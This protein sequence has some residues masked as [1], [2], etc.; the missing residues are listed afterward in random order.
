MTRTGRIL[1]VT[2]GLVGAG[3]VFG[4]LAGALALAI[5]LSITDGLATATRS[6]TL[7]LP[8][9][10]GAVLG[11]LALPIAGWL[12]L[13]RVPLGRAVAG[14]VVGTVAGGAVV[15]TLQIGGFDTIYYSLAG[16]FAGFIL[17]CLIMWHR[18]R[19]A[20]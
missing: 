13:R 8:A 9:A 11:G 16:A 19:A 5:G 1:L 12:V 6:I 18:A 14:C 4:A 7:Q 2:L 15:W 17:A 3:A 10:L 20:V